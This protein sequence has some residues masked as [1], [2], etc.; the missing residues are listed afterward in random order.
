MR[1]DGHH[2]I[3]EVLDRRYRVDARIA[4]GGMSTVFRGLDLRL[5]RPVAIKVM[6]AQFAADPKFLAR[7]EF[8]A[9][10]VARLKH[11]GLVAVYDQGHDG[12]LAFLVMELVEGGTL[13]E[14][15]RERGPMPPHA[16][17][18]VAEPVLSALGVAHA[19]GLV[20]R[21]IKPENVLISDNGDVKLA[22]F[23]LVRAVAAS[24]VTSNSVILG[25]AAYLSPEQVSNGYA[26]AR[27]D[28]YSMGVLVF[29]ML[30]GGTPFNADTS[31]SV[32]YQRLEKDVP[33]PSDFIEGVPHEFD[34][35]VAE[36][37]SREP[38]HRFAD[39]AEMA[40][41]LRTIGRALELPEY[42]VP[43]PERSAE[44]AS[45]R[46]AP[47]SPP[48]DDP[49]RTDPHRRRPDQQ[50]PVD[51]RSAGPH[52]TT[53]EFA[54][55]ATA[56]V[57]PVGP[58]AVDRP[59]QHQ[60]VH[61][62]TKVVTGPTPRRPDA[63]PG[64]SVPDEP[65][66]RQYPYPDFIEDR[67]RSRR[68]M[69]V[70]L[71]IIALL[72]VAVGVG[73][74]WLGSGRYTAVPVISGLDRAAA[75]ERLTDA[76]LRTELRNEHS[77]IVPVDAIIGT[78]PAAGSRVV[79]DSTVALLISLGKPVVPDVVPGEAVDVVEQRLRDAGLRPIDGGTAYSTNA[80]AGSVATLDPAPGTEV[81]VDS[82]V[83]VVRSK[84]LPPVTL[85]DLKGQ[86]E[87]EAR[88]TL[89]TQGI[90]LRAS[91]VIFDSSVDGGSVIR[92]EPAA[93]AQVAGGSEVT[94][95]VSN[96]V[97]VPDVTGQS[98]NSARDDLTAAG[99]DV[100]VRQLAPI[101]ASL[102]IAQ[103]PAGG[104]RVQPGSSVTITSFP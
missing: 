73:G 62:H 80:A 3:G 30:T 44:H 16:V 57:Q 37:T 98:V 11:P 45:A 76:G 59:V 23:G 97:K 33:S 26:D 104:K 85:P 100:D 83:K 50:R 47:V 74:W 31:L 10:A 53:A 6:D 66:Q 70:W 61:H 39:A 101:N 4:R 58:H 67:R 35:F 88:R 41:A 25:T 69:I 81:A 75:T 94:L 32:A 87:A 19:A 43:A 78:D 92:S 79:R 64:P 89:E 12:E 1:I 38:S 55:S 82:E 42:R 48:F 56:I 99:L 8:E 21:D 77:D 17:C 13:R 52:P 60:P 102:V 5:D 2:L 15:L 72:A 49:E 71:L 22:D 34:E 103:N 90:T 51:V 40:G 95:V 18:G 86:T 93:G 36:A 27:S 24:N 84:G 96:A 14:L 28:V 46:P 63:Y 91:Q 9:R 7:F 65:D 20:H 68:T 29:E 54:N